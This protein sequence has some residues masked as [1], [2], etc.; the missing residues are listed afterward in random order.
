MGRPGYVRMEPYRR[1]AREKKVRF[2]LDRAYVHSIYPQTGLC[3]LCHVLMDWS[4]PQ[5]SVKA[6]LDRIYPARG[7]TKGNVR[8]ICNRCNLDRSWSIVTGMCYS[9]RTPATGCISTWVT[10][11]GSRGSP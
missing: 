6:V 5:T 3:P 2:D 10:P 7:Y 8:W 11:P 1:R 4:G 9:W